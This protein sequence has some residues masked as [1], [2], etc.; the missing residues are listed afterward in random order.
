MESD[1]EGYSQLTTDDEE[2]SDE[3]TRSTRAINR[4]GGAQDPARSIVAAARG[5]SSCLCMLRVAIAQY[6]WPRGDEG[7]GDRFVGPDPRRDQSGRCRDLAR[8]AS[9]LGDVQATW[10]AASTR[11]DGR[12]RSE[13]DGNR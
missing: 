1:L 5:S 9:A 12:A 3:E 11:P 4:R 13:R 2:V 6:A 8:T 7:D 10:P